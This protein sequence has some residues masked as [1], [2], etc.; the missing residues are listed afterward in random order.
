M[1]YTLKNL[2]SNQAVFYGFLVLGVINIVL[3][4]CTQ[5]YE[6]LGTLLLTAYV[7]NFVTRN[8]TVDIIVALIVANVIFG[9][10]VY[11]KEAFEPAS[12]EEEEEE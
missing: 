12:E 9:C 10:G 3:Y 1:A 6:C 4:L 8:R 5:R 7:S 11:K 2:L